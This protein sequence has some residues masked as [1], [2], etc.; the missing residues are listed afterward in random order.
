MVRVFPSLDTTCLKMESG[1]PG[2]PSVISVEYA[3]IRFNEMRLSPS[4]PEMWS[5]ASYLAIHCPPTPT[6]SPFSFKRST[7]CFKLSPSHHQVWMSEVLGA[8]PELYVDF[9]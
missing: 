7:L 2:T 1:L 8:G 4:P 3:S 9:S 5:A 6:T